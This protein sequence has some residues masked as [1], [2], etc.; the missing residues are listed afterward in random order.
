MAGGPEPRATAEARPA[1]R[2]SCSI[3][4]FS[5]WILSK[6]HQLEDRFGRR[7]EAS[8]ATSYWGSLRGYHV[9]NDDDPLAR[10]RSNFIADVLVPELGMQSVLE[11]GTNSGRNLG[12]VKQRHPALRAK[13]IDVNPRAL[14]HARE[15]HP[16]VEFVQQDAN[17]WTEPPGAWDGILTMSLLDHIPD[18]EASMLAANMAASGR[19]MICFELWDG[20]D[21]ARG[22]YK[23]SRDTRRLFESLGVKTRRWEL[24]PGQYD[25][26]HSMLWLYVGET[27]ED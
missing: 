7:G 25:L 3:L 12:I 15:H 19:F 1:D 26:E 14:N 21:G 22:L 18:A 4:S 11:I 13:G 27:A 10:E 20:E 17:R 2:L 8:R 9:G 6:R 23:Y 5:D 24:S 16:D